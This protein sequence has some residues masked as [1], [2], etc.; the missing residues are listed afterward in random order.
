MKVEDKQAY[1]LLYPRLTVLVSSG[2][3]KR[4]NAMTVAWATPLSFK[5]PL[6]GVAISPKRYSHQIIEN[7]KKFAINIPTTQLAEQTYFFGQKSGEEVNK[8]EKSNLTPVMGKTGVPVIEECYANIECELVD[9][10]VFGDHTLFVGKIKNAEVEEDAIDENGFPK[11]E[12]GM[13]YWKSSG[14]KDDYVS[15]G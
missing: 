3:Q 2:D 11:P 4:K 6:V 7:T 5:P 1:K 8:F 9:K 14:I 10:P 12:K 15:F 13:I